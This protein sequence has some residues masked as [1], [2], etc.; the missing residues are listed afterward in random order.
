MEKSKGTQREERFLYFTLTGQMR[1]SVD[2]VKIGKCKYLQQSLKMLYKDILKNTRDTPKWNP[3]THSSNPQKVGKGKHRDENRE[4]KEKTK[5]LCFHTHEINRWEH[6]TFPTDFGSI[7]RLKSLSH[8][9]LSFP[10][11]KSTSRWQFTFS[12]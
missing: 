3:K 4:N 11:P 12:S 1:T 9:L 8:C 6:P 10:E 2:C 5:C 7:N